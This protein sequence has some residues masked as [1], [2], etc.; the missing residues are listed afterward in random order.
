MKFRGLG[1]KALLCTL[2]FPGLAFSAGGEKAPSYRVILTP[3]S[4]AVLSARLTSEVEAINYRMGEAFQKGAVLVELRDEVLEATLSKASALLERA[5][6]QKLAKQKQFDDNSASLFELKDA[7]ANHAAASADKTIAQSDLD[8]SVITAPYNGRVENVFVQ[9]FETVQTGQ[10]L[11][12]IVNDNTLVA[13]F[14]V[15][16]NELR[17]TAI[18]KIIQI[19]LSDNG[20]TVPASISNIGAVIDPASSMVKVYAEIDNSDGKLKAGMVG[21]TDLDSIEEEDDPSVSIKKEG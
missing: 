13:R 5:K 14:L 15:P 19:H 4:Q 9:T 17:R 16:S 3:K 18:G 12:E 6:V 10:P 1:L 20:E 21:D 2:L 11:L 7:L 8:N